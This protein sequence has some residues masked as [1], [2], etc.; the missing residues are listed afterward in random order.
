MP[1][2]SLKHFG[3]LGMR[4]GHRKSP[5]EQAADNARREK[6]HIEEMDRRWERDSVS[7]KKSVQVYNY[8]ARKMN[9]GEITRI[10]NLPKY[11][12]KNLYAD[13]KLME[14]YNK[15]FERSY[16]QALQ[17]GSDSI[18]GRN[19]SNTKR[20][21]VEG[22]VDWGPVFSFEDIKHEFSKLGVKI[23]RDQNGFITSIEAEQDSL[24]ME[25][26]IEEFLMHFGIP[27]MRWGV[28][29]KRNTSADN[30]SARSIQKKHISEMSN[31]ELKKL[32]TRLQLER[33]YK[34]LNPSTIAAGR[35]LVANITA[36]IGKQL[37][38]N[39][40]TKAATVGI[41]A[42]LRKQGLDKFTSLK[43]KD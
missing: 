43:E 21:R 16:T 20:V 28:R 10:N 6:A 34:D 13:K 38:K 12:N 23:V 29:R 27:G 1:D 42:V 2:N 18:F 17:E 25:N 14:S 35:K 15:D 41:D 19:P 4:W 30:D 11:K 31:D 5:Q 8:A 7:R 22:G 40:T 26:N 32:T 36:D 24:Q 39:Y 9:A 33:Q 37:V 3:I